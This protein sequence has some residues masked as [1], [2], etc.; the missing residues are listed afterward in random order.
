MFIKQLQLSRHETSRCS[1]K[2]AKTR[3]D[4]CFCLEESGCHFEK[5]DVEPDALVSLNQDNTS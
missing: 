1:T 4:Y 5:Q 3:N 2:S